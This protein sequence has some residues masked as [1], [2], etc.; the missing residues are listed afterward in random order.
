MLIALIVAVQTAEPGAWGG[1]KRDPV[2][3]SAN[4]FS[5]LIPEPLGRGP[6]TL[7]ISDGNA[8]TRVD[9][10]S[11]SGCGRA[12]DAVRRQVAAPPDTPYRIYGLSTVK[13]FCVPR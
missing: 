6:H 5:D 13:A 10:K 3:R 2:V 12:R 4:P 9:Y 8:M 1:Y 11:G 7:V